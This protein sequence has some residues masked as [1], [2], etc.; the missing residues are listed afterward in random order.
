MALEH[1]ARTV[2][3]AA[4][5]CRA[6]P[7]VYRDGRKEGGVQEERDPTNRFTEMKLACSRGIARNRN[8]PLADRILVSVEK[9][10]NDEWTR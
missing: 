7:H 5:V 2:L 6:F 10:N 9:M 1:K 4:E 3:P 8:D